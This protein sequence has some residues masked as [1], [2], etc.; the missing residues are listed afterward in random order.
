MNGKTADFHPFTFSLFGNAAA[1]AA[2]DG[3]QLKRL[4]L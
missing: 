4:Y 2:R 1:R 3:A